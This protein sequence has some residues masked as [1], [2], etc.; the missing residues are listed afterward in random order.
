[1]TVTADRAVDAAP[2][3]PRPRDA[4]HLLSLQHP[5]R[6]VEGR[7]RDQR[8]DRRRGPLPAP[9]PRPARRR[10]ATR[11]TGTL[12]PLEAAARRLVG[13]LL[14]RPR[15]PV[16][17]RRGLRRAP[18]RRRPAPTPR[19][20]AAPPRSSATPAAS[21]A[22]RV[23]T[24]MWLVAALALVV[25]GRCRRS[26]PSRS[27]CRRARRSRSTPSA[28]GRGRRS[29]RCRSS[30]RCEPSTPVALRDRRAAA[31]APPPSRR[32]RSLGPRLRACST[33]PLHALRAPAGRPAAPPRPA[34]GRA[35][36]RRAAGA[37]RLLGRDPAAVGLVDR[38][39]CTRS[40]TPSTTR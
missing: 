39:R 24:R 5:R 22:S 35:L 28:A 11:A 30:R 20:C 32:R 9:L 21:S 14:R 31:R 37:R 23:F 12:D 13:D 19:T 16:D 1:M 15:R 29:S 25:G 8:D 34:H 26:R 6:L 7:A 40:A 4:T 38:S 17:D 27:C 2:R 36:D 10:R 3:A 33:A 18:P